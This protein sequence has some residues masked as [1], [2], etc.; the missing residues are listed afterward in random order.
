MITVKKE[1]PESI[2]FHLSQLEKEEQTKFKASRRR[3]IIKIQGEINETENIKI[4]KINEKQQ[5]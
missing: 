2:R 3:D 4:E 1:Y 5:D